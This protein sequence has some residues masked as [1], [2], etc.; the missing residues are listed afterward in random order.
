MGGSRRFGNIRGADDRK[1][2][3]LQG[4]GT[5]AVYREFICLGWVGVLF[6][7]AHWVLGGECLNK[8]L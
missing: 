8:E 6:G 2:L 7:M 1:G 5:V 3:C 4:G